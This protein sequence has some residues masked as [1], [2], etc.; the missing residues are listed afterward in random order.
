VS[1]ANISLLQPHLQCQ[2]QLNFS[3]SVP[4]SSSFR[5]Y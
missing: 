4:R 5:M 3:L 1:G 2:N